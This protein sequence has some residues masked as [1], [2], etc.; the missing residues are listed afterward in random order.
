MSDWGKLDIGD[1]IGI[2]AGGVSA[3]IAGAFSYMNGTKKSLELKMEQLDGRMDCY[4]EGYASHAT[5]IAVV[6]NCQE[7]TAATLIMLKDQSIEVNR[8]LDQLII[9]LAERRH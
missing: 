5:K 2:V 6:Q 1:Y 4:D 8:K 3:G 9:S 7:N